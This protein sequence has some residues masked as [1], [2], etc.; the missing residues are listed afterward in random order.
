MIWL[1]IPPELF[2]KTKKSVTSPSPL[3]NWCGPLESK[4][5]PL[6]SGKTS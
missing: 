3:T 1:I 2:S 5:T 6:S 4:T